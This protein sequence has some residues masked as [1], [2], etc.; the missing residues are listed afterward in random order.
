MAEIPT[1]ITTAVPT[2]AV[3]PATAIK[4]TTTSGLENLLI[5]PWTTFLN[6]NFKWLA[7]VTIRYA[8]PGVV[9]LF[10]LIILFTNVSSSLHCGGTAT[11]PVIFIKNGKAINLS[12]PSKDT[13]AE[14]VKDIDAMIKQLQA[15]KEKNK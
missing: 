4:T 11:N 7:G 6:K 13:T 3:T 14:D 12:K 15:L 2:V 10:V 1:T 5:E 8:I 9:I